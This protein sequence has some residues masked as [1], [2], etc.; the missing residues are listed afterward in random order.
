MKGYMKGIKRPPVIGLLLIALAVIL[1][2]V[3]PIA[4]IIAFPYTLAGIVLV[5]FGFWLA[6]SGKGRFEK[7]GTAV[8]FGAPSK[9]V[10][11]GLYAR[12]RNPMYLGLEIFLLGVSILLGSLSGFLAPIAFFLI[13]NFAFIPHEEKLLNQT[14]GEEYKAYKKHVRRWL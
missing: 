3:F 13:I 14:F 9:L 4:R 5:V 10:T 12:S 11:D 6:A 1:H 2:F 8:R 7:E